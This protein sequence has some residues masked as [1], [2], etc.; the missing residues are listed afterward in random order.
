MDGNW[1]IQDYLLCVNS[2]SRFH[3]SQIELTR[4]H[5]KCFKLDLE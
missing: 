3:A 2:G 1:L 5:L 4:C